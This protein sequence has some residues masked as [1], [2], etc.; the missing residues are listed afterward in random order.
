MRLVNP[1]K[2]ADCPNRRGGEIGTFVARTV[3]GE[4]YLA[5]GCE[6]RAPVIHADEPFYYREWSRSEIFDVPEYV[7]G[8]WET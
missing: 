4:G 6:G 3:L 7:C 1:N 8:K 5:P 2:C